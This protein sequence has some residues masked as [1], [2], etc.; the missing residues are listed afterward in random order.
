MDL[1]TIVQTLLIRIW[2]YV[3]KV[4]V[5]SKNY[6]LDKIGFNF[7]KRPHSSKLL[8]K[9]YTEWKGTQSLC[10]IKLFFQRIAIILDL[11]LVK[12]VLMKDFQYFNHRG[13]YVNAVDDPLSAHILALSGS[14]WKKIRTKVT[15]TF[16]TG[17]M[18]MMFPTF[19]QV[20]KQFK[21]YLMQAVAEDNEIEMKNVL[22]RFTTD[23]IGNCGYGIEC[24]SLMD[25]DAKFIQM[26]YKVLNHPRSSMLKQLFAISFPR[27][28]RALRLTITA[29]DV[30]KFFLGVVRD[31]VEYREVNGIQRNDFMNLLI[32]LKNRGTVDDN[33]VNEDG[34]LTLNEI[35]AQ[36]FI[37]FIAG[38]ETSS[39]VMAF[40]VYELSLNQDIQDRARDCVMDVLLRHN[41]ELTYEA[42]TEMTY[43]DHCIN[44]NFLNQ[45]R[46]CCTS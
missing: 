22:S 21:E 33:K 42:L 32:Q 38:S 7:K 3:E 16:S 13:L 9:H 8:Q 30:S 39:T 34:K 28:A 12:N 41:G 5:I 25:P 15:P 14:S 23:V 2:R 40:T 36:A 35:S 6:C 20:G 11:D 46:I 27:L 18:K 1:I 10:F 19:V 4:Y 43:L 17:K 45:V 31:T 44:G 26:A 29:P 24:N 37:F